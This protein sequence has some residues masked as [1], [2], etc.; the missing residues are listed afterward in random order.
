MRVLITENQMQAVNDLMIYQTLQ[1]AITQTTRWHHYTQSFAE[2][3][4]LGDFY[5]ELIDLMDNFMEVYLANNGRKTNVDFGMKYQK[6]SKGVATQY[7]NVLKN[8]M[9]AIKDQLPQGSLHGVVDEITALI[10]KT[11]YLLTLD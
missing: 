1:H 8:K 2:H 4:A 10:E 9:Y 5:E 11:I 3:T 6:Y 7:F